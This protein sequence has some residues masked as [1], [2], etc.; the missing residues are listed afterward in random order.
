MMCQY[1][2]LICDQIHC[3]EDIFGKET[4][5]QLHFLVFVRA[6]FVG[7]ALYFN[8]RSMYDDSLKRREASHNVYLQRLQEDSVVCK[9]SQTK[10]IS[11]FMSDV[12]VCCRRGS[13]SILH[14]PMK[15]GQFLPVLTTYT[16]GK[17]FINSQLTL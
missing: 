1:M 2:N 13:S 7:W 9:Y 14:Q 16:R 10:Y 8:T 15:C 17:A 11:L 3:H 4:I 5:H 12:S 6:N